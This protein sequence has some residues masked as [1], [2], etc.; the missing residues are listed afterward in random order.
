L[1]SADA[2]C[3]ASFSESDPGRLGVYRAFGP[4]DTTE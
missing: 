2:G 4:D 3:T 1:R